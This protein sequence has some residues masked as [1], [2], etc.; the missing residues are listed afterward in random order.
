MI[1]NVVV[2][3]AEITLTPRAVAEL[4]LRVGQIC[5][6]AYGAAV[7]IGSCVS[8]LERR[9]SIEGNMTGFLL[10]RFALE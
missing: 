7:G 9:R 10:L 4:Q 5:A 2:T 3:V 6:A 1:G 8:V